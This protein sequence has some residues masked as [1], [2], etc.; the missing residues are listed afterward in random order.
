M[1]CMMDLEDIDWKLPFRFLT[2]FCESSSFKTNR[3][4]IFSKWSIWKWEF[5]R[6]STQISI[7]FGNGADILSNFFTN[8]P[9]KIKNKWHNT[10]AR[11]APFSIWFSLCDT[12]LKWEEKEM[13]TKK[14]YFNNENLCTSFC[15]QFKSIGK[16]PWR[17]LSI[18]LI[19][20][21]SAWRLK[22]LTVW[23]LFCEL[24][25]I[26]MTYLTRNYFH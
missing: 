10:R 17:R 15:T 14:N 11:Y 12:S 13:K 8:W 23:S 3:L 21:I 20:I 18:A 5:V 22:C 4:C 9:T 19:W 6:F 7:R 24:F 25:G 1:F 16:F 26:I 2:N